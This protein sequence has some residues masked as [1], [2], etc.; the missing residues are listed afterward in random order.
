MGRYY[1]DSAILLYS[2]RSRMPVVDLT[3]IRSFHQ[4][5]DSS[6]DLRGRMEHNNLY[7]NYKYMMKSNSSDGSLYSSHFVIPLV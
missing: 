2:H 7:Y 3:R 5:I 6:N 4:G 1:V